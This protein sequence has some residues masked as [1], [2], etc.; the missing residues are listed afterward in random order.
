MLSL[1]TL[2]EKMVAIGASDLHVKI[3]RPPVVRIH[4]DLQPMDFDR[5]T[6]QDMDNFLFDTLQDEDQI[7]FKK[8][9]GI[10]VAYSLPGVSRFRVNALFQR[11]TVAMIIRT[12]PF[13]I[14][15]LADLGLPA[16]VK[17]LASLNSGMVLVTGPA[18]SG[19]STTLAAIIDYIN[20][21]YHKQVIT[22]EDP[23]EFL[24][25]DDKSSI[26]QREVGVDTINFADG[27]RMVFRQ[28]PDVI[29]VGEMRDLETIATAVS[30]AETGHLV[31]STLH[32]LDSAQTIDR[33]IDAFPQAQQRQIRIQLSQ[34]MKGVIAQRLVP[35]KEMTGRCAAVEVMTNS[36]AVQDIVLN[37]RTHELYESVRGAVE[38]FGMQ[39]LE[40][41][42][43][44]LLV[45]DLINY[46][47]AKR[48]CNRTAEL[49]AAVRALFPDY[50]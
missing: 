17:E 49:D 23:I 6:Q 34:V 47:E 50:I 37:G 4:G 26:I 30:A 38:N 22:I 3:G 27:L 16:T 1:N 18:G 44:A 15:T 28:D 7:K 43:V 39:T 48:F 32:T 5:I 21:N 24:F 40:Q 36:P 13:K 20:S 25:K 35:N 31:L 2:L 42:L 33:I 10:D 8:N 45:H 14:P 12:I 11:G 9:R 19:K 29:V 46:D 41:S